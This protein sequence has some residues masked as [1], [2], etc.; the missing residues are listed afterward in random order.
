M[1]GTRAIEA[2]P[3]TSLSPARE[4]H[5]FFGTPSVIELTNPHGHASIADTFSKGF[6]TEFGFFSRHST[7]GRRWIMAKKIVLL[8]DG[9]GNSAGK[10]WRTNVW[11]VFESLE[12]KGS[13]QI[14]IY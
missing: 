11:R 4:D 6:Q 14:A 1:A 10:V 13:D 12:L 5:S 9:T 3:I 2:T 8:S 7:Y